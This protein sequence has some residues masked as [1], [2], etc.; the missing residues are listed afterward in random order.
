MKLQKTDER[1]QRGSVPAVKEATPK[2]VRS[3][4]N[5]HHRGPWEAFPHQ[6]GLCGTCSAHPAEAPSE[7]R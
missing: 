3:T 6:P 2:W 5:S 1:D 7:W 4:L